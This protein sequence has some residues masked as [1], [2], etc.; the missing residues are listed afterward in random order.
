[1]FAFR[2]IRDVSVYLVYYDTLIRPVYLTVLVNLENFAKLDL[3][4]WQNS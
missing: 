2:N 3:P 4:F 1:M